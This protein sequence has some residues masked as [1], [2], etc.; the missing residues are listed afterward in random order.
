M[1]GSVIAEERALSCL[2]SG[3]KVSLYFVL[4]NVLIFSACAYLKCTAIS[5]NVVVYQG[6]TTPQDH[7]GSCK[8]HY[9]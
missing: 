7:V 5:G 6:H 8:I 9:N 4:L 2:T 3:L 1:I